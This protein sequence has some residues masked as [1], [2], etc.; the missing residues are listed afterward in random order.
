MKPPPAGVPLPLI[1]RIP[2]KILPSGFPPGRS[3]LLSMAAPFPEHC[4]DDLR[5][6]WGTVFTGR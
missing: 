2:A 1:S 3:S 4:G 6:R 5:G